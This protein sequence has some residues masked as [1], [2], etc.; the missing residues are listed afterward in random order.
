MHTG[1]LWN[2]YWTGTD[3]DQSKVHPAILLPGC[4]ITGA[5]IESDTIENH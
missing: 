5:N 4:K 2:N 3:K 1:V